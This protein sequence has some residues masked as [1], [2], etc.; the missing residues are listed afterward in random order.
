MGDRKFG[1]METN[2]LTTK[3]VKYDPSDTAR[4]IVLWDEAILNLQMLS[5]LGQVVQ[6]KL[7]D[8]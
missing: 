3:F 5:S 8:I 6:H 7:L 2:S 1:S 4:I